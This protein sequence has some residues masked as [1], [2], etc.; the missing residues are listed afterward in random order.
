MVCIGIGRQ[1]TTARAA[2]KQLNCFQQSVT[3]GE[4]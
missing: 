2:V 3:F 1:H 4:S